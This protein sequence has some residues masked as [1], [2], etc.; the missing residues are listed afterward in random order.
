[1]DGS[2]L[3]IG[4]VMIAEGTR[5]DPRRDAAQPA[6]EDWCWPAGAPS[7]SRFGGT[8]AS[9]HADDACAAAGARRLAGGAATAEPYRGTIP[10]A[11]WRGFLR[12]RMGVGVSK[13]GL[14]HEGAGRVG[15]SPIVGSGFY[16]DASLRRRGRHRPG[17]GHHAGC[18][19]YEAVSLMRRG[20]SPQEACDET[21]TATACAFETWATRT[22]ASA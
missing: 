10:C 22:A 3:R 20:A 17:R 5:I 9:R 14:F 18:L 13:S 19:S 4:G 12:P 16:C 6:P 11:C 8:A 21:L 7:S 15:D 2:T 1:M